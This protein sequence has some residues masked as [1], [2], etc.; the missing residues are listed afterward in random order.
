MFLCYS[1]T[2]SGQKPWGKW[3]NF[4]YGCPL[5]HMIMY[6]FL[7]RICFYH[8]MWLWQA[9]AFAPLPFDQYASSK[10]IW[11]RGMSEVFYHAKIAFEM[12]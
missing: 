9:D 11:N 4:M 7:G 5:K 2:P 1:L 3:F 10:F 12:M 6:E 8:I